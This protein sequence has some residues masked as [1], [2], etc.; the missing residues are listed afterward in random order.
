MR[1]SAAPAVDLTSVWPRDGRLLFTTRVIRLFAYGLIS[2]VLALYLARIGFGEAQ[3]GMLLTLMLAGDAALSLWM[4]TR[5]DRLGRRPMLLAGAVLM[6]VA[7]AAF[8]LVESWPA[9][10]LAAIVGTLSPSGNEVGAFLPI[11]QAG[12]AQTIPDRQRTHVFAWY[13]LAGSLATACGALVGGASVQWLLPFGV[14]P[15]A[16]YR[17]VFAAYAGL[18]AVLLI[19]FSRLSSA[20]EATHPPPAAGLFGLSRSRRIVARL[21]ALFALDAFAGGLILQ[22]LVAYWFSVR[23]GADPA[24]I[25]AIFFGGNILAGLSALAAARI[26]ARIGLV[27]TMVFT[28]IPSN[29]LLMLVPLMPSLPLAVAVL[30]TRFSLSQMDVPTR[31]SYVMAVVDPAERSAAA[32]LTGLARTVGAACSPLLAGLLL[33]G[34]WLSAPFWAAGGLKIAYD[35]ALYHNFRRVTPP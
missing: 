5:A 12:L 32:G 31:Q 9:L 11:E 34:G 18:G 33:G 4:T 35:L 3:I 26:A 23:F 13:N 27:P 19:L 6:I 24:V 14:A 15:P 21:S 29:V 30:L 25:G 20:V 16:S 7:G 28:H 10:T 1:R 2:V 17:L 8:A 22:S